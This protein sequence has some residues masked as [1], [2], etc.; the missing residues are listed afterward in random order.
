MLVDVVDRK[1]KQRYPAVS[2]CLE[3]KSMAYSRIDVPKERL[4][5]SLDVLRGT[6]FTSRSIRLERKS[7]VL[8]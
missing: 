4:Q 3:R 2:V 5:C 7:K 6:W 8:F 1:Q